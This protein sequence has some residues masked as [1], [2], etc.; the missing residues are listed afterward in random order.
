MPADTIVSMN[1]WGLH[2]DIFP[3]L[4]E[5]F[6]AFTAVADITKDEFPIPTAI[7]HLIKQGKRRVRVYDTH[8]VWY[9]MTYRE[10]KAKVTEAIA[11]MTANGCYPKELW[12]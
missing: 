5:Q 7:D 3:E 10:D 8:A 2:P 1:M 4:R 11:A 9:G 12:T 6:A